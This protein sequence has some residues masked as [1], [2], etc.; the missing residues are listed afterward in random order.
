[1]SWE[2]VLVR[3]FIARFLPHGTDVA[4]EESGLHID[5]CTAAMD[6]SSSVT[7]SAV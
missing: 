4:I 3:D 2:V 7:V 6:L 1:M 5:I